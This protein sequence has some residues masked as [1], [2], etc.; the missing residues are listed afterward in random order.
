MTLS[1]TGWDYTVYGS[2][3]LLDGSTRSAFHTATGI[4]ATQTG[5]KLLLLKTGNILGVWLLILL[6]VSQPFSLNSRLQ[7]PDTVFN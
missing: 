7:F 2:P 5:S 1:G 6:P 3:V 4:R